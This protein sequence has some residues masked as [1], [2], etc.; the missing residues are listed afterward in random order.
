M[1]ALSASNGYVK[2]I[3]MDIVMDARKLQSIFKEMY[4]SGNDAV[5]KVQAFNYSGTQSVADHAQEYLD[6]FNFCKKA[7][8]K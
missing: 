5:D 8:S 1:F 6:T 4:S 7:L 2:T 3:P